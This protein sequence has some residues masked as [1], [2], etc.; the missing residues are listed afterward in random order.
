M[1]TV[2]YLDYEVV[3]EQGWDLRDPE[4]FEK[5]SQMDLPD[6]EYGSLEVREGQFILDTAESNGLDWPFMC[7]AGACA[8]CSAVLID[9]EIEM[10]DQQILTGDEVEDKDIRLTCI[11][12]PAT[13]HVRIIFNA[14]QLDYLQDRVL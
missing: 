2:E 5:A 9:G 4:N 7:R 12:H 8:N 14:K 1:P 11:G 3:E 13:D 6:S 10:E